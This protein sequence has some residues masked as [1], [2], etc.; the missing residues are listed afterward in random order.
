MSDKKFKSD[1]H[2][3]A[4]DRLLTRR[5]KEYEE[6]FGVKIVN[7]KELKMSIKRFE[8]IIDMTGGRVSGP[9]FRRAEKLPSEDIPA[10]NRFQEHSRTLAAW[11]TIPV[12]KKFK[13]GSKSRDTFFDM[14]V[15]LDYLGDLYDDVEKHKKLMN[16]KRED[17]RARHSEIIGKDG[18]KAI[19][20]VSPASLSY[21]ILW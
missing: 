4:Y 5:I 10:F 3:Q 15:R 2:V 9:D 8:V 11:P 12:L 16:K 1:S 19:D 21:Y 20:Y 14:T 18:M 17:Y 13:F 7:I 6:R